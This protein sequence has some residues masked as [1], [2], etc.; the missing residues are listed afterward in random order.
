MTR[1][2]HQVVSLCPACSECPAV[3]I[4][5][6]DEVRIGEARNIVTLTAAEWNELVR[7]VRDGVLT[8]VDR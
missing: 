1:E 7:A 2:P 3:A 8:E 6:T 4:Y 5:D